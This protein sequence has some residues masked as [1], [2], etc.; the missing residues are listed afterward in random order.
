M[1]ATERDE[2]TCQRCLRDC[3]GSQRHHRQPRD[4][5][6]TLLSNLIVLGSTCHLD[7]TTHPRDAIAQGWSMPRHTSVLPSQWPARRWLPTGK[8]TVQLGWVLLLDAPDRGV[9]WLE[10]PDDEAAARIAGL[11]KEVA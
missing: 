3:G 11:L 10:I 4:G 7:V 2:D 1:L 9:W 8:G 6:N 5:R